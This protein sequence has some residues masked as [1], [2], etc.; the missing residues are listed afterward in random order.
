MTDSAPV[1]KENRKD[2]ETA[3]KRRTEHN[4]VAPPGRGVCRSLCIARHCAKISVTD[5]LQGRA[6]RQRQGRPK[7]WGTA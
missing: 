5:R 3:K 1:W 2:L 6:R 4:D 7:K